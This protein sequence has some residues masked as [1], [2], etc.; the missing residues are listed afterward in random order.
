MFI[1]IDN[2]EEYRQVGWPL[3]LK[4]AF[5]EVEGINF[6]ICFPKHSFITSTF[7]MFGSQKLWAEKH[8]FID[9]TCLLLMK[10]P[11]LKLTF[12]HCVL[13]TFKLIRN[14][15]LIQLVKQFFQTFLQ[16]EK[17]IKVVRWKGTFP[18]YCPQRKILWSLCFF[19][20]LSQGVKTEFWGVLQIKWVFLVIKL[21]PISV[22]S[23]VSSKISQQP[24]YKAAI[25]P[26]RGLRQ[27]KILERKWN[28][29]PLKEFFFYPHLHL[30][31]SCID[32]PNWWRQYSDCDFWK[33]QLILENF[34]CSSE[35]LNMLKLRNHKFKL[36]KGY[37]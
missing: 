14:M 19:S 24:N 3:L 5:F 34:S 11:P 21:Q 8:C 12:K 26:K 1:F 32:Y 33:R 17:M 30:N 16:W 28:L 9:K 15:N 35:N 7:S 10:T 29:L 27:Y 6:L 36:K 18:I 37:L 2:G 31:C 22:T 25:Q 4:F 20:N 23:L 13:T